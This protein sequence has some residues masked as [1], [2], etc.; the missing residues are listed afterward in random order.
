MAGQDADAAIGCAHRLGRQAE[1]AYQTVTELL[2]TLRK[3]G[4]L[5]WDAV[6]D[7][8][9]ELDTWQVYRSPREARAQMRNRYDEDRWLGQEFFPI[10]IVEKDTMEPVCQPIAMRWQMRF[11][12]SRG[13]GSLTLQHDVAKLIIERGA[14]TGQMA[15]RRSA[16]TRSIVS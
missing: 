16:A 4:G 12:S 5:G 6:L 10:F 3:Q 2:G 8:T 11:A 15:G 13:Y 7:L 9:R 1:A 14:R